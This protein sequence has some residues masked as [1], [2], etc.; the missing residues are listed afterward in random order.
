MFRIVAAGPG[1]GEDLSA[2]RRRHVI[3]LALS[4]LGSGAVDQAARR[5]IVD[6]LAHTLAHAASAAHFVRTGV[7]PH[8]LFA[9]LSPSAREAPRGLPYLLRSLAL[10]LL[11]VLPALPRPTRLAAAPDL[12]EPDPWCGAPAPSLVVST[13][14]GSAGTALDLPAGLTRVP[15]FDV[16]YDPWP[17]PLAE[18]WREAGGEAYAGIGMLLQQALLQVRVFVGGDPGIPLDREAEVLAAMEAAAR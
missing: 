3:E 10:T 7:L 8:L 5:A 2:Y 6:L 15:L 11:P 1:A 18:R 16:A 12:A 17:S 9:L 13:L 4:L 14:P